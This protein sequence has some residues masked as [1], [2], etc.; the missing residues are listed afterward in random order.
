MRTIFT[1]VLVTLL[2]TAASAQNTKWLFLSDSTFA[3]DAA[4]SVAYDGAG[5]R[6]VAGWFAGIL[7]LSGNQYVSDFGSTDN[8]TSTPTKGFVS[9]YSSA[10]VLLWT[11]TFMGRG[12]QWCLDIEVNKTTGECY[13][14]GNFT[15]EL[16]LDGV[17][18]DFTDGTYFGRPFIVKFDANGNKQWINTTM[19]SYITNGSYSI[20]L[21]PNGNDL[22]WHSDFI[23]DLQINGSLAYGSIGGDYVLMRLSTASGAITNAYQTSD[24]LQDGIMLNCDNSGNVYWSGSHRN[25][26]Y[27]IANPAYAL[28]QGYIIKFDPALTTQ[29][30]AFEV[31]GKGFQT[32]NSTA[33][34]AAGNVYIYGRFDDTTRFYNNSG[35]DQ[36]VVFIPVP[37]RTNGYVAKVSK[38]GN[39]L[40]AKQFSGDGLTFDNYDSDAEA[41]LTVDSRNDVYFGGAFGTGKIYVDTDSLQN[42]TNHL[43][44]YLV[45]LTPQGNLSWMIKPETLRGGNMKGLAAYSTNVLAAGEITGVYNFYADNYFK[46][47][48]DSVGNDYNAQYLWELAD[49]AISIKTKITSNTVNVSNPDT[50]SVSNMPNVTYQWY[51]NGN[52][53]NGATNNVYITT[54]PGTY[55]CILDNGIC[56]LES[57]R[58]RIT[59][60]PSPFVSGAEYDDAVQAGNAIVSVYPNPVKDRFTI[61]T[62]VSNGNH[63]YEIKVTD[64]NG[65][66]ILS[67]KINAGTQMVHLPNGTASGL[68]LLQVVGGDEPVTIKLLVQ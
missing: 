3:R 67:K 30:W 49:C 48:N 4:N 15:T 12:A 28:P 54:R 29:L 34:D 60:L 41:A 26:G 58:K 38:A 66:I 18:Q 20:G 52:A 5:N 46:Y 27:V 37:G 39:L 14:A 16:L 53:I 22:Y 40:W 6:Y 62:P 47:A 43:E 59:L 55:Y 68:Y 19:S 57:T 65:R 23:G 44:P 64:V 51:R 42:T 32:L 2:Y 50:L 36:G 31:S 45:K 25:S 24:Y 10:G 11:K 63:V 9:K 13:V 7:K 33:V 21:S 35:T 8:V 56:Q 17:R 1:V 61:N